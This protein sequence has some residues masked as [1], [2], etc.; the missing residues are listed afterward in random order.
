M[1]GLDQAFI[2]AYRVQPLPSPGADG[3]SDVSSRPGPNGRNDAGK[4]TWYRIDR[5]IQGLPAGKSNLPP[6][7]KKVPAMDPYAFEVST[8]DATSGVT[9]EAAFVTANVLGWTP[10]TVPSTPDVPL[11]R[12]SDAS[13]AGGA[14]THQEAVAPAQ[15]QVSPTATAADRDSAPPPT[16]PVGEATSQP[17]VTPEEENLQPFKPVWEVDRFAWPADV[18]QLCEVEAAY[19]AHAGRKLQ[20][21]AREGLR[22]LAV[23][24]A[25]AGEGCTTLAICL[26]RAAVEAGVRVALLDANLARPQLGNRLGISFPH[27]WIE[28]L[29]GDVPLGETAIAAVEKP[30]TVLPLPLAARSDPAALDGR[31]SR[32]VRSVAAVTELVIIDLG[33]SSQETAHWWPKGDRCPI[34][35]AIVVRDTRLTA[36]NQTLAAANALRQMG[37]SAVGIAE[38][39]VPCQQAAEKAAA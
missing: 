36:E 27:G 33:P 4:R 15:Q 29:S 2:D 3:T 37:V 22:V 9:A 18:E 25:S 19:F 11:P 23:T 21:A 5:G 12:Q 13:P 32:L 39:Y 20:E 1:T 24:S 26:A 8:W 31:V 34:D 17:E 38:N 16:D 28:S 14:P 10:P 35:A 30:L 7:P 6:G